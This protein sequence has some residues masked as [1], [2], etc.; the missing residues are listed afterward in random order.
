MKYVLINQPAG[1][2]D[3]F[4]LQK[5]A[6]L[7][8]F[9]DYKIIW[10]VIKEFEYVKDYLKYKNITFVNK[11]H[12]FLFK[13]LYEQNHKQITEHAVGD[14]TVLV[15]P[16]VHSLPK[17][18]YSSLNLTDKDWQTHFS[19][20]RNHE[21]EQ[22]LK[23]KYGIKDGEEFI[24]INN[25]FASPPDMITRDIPISTDKKIIYNNGEPCHV[26]DFC[27]LFEN[28]SE[29]HLVES[30]FCYFIEVLDTKG[31]L[32]MYSRKI[33]GRNQHPNF[34]YVNHIYKKDWIKIN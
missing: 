15:L 9:N 13:D 21:R 25:I 10:P 30:S 8:E 24:F 4:Y 33:N 11:E 1:L 18:K 31:K 16:L 23:E 12:D 19:F 28:A 14:D 6:K 17:N 3:I 2:G 5:A 26:F 22:Q 32:F 7:L 34:D 29:L 20:E 27:W